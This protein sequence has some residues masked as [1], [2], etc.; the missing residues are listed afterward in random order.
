[1]MVKWANYVLLKAN[2]GNML[3]NYGEMLVNDGEMIVND[4]EISIKGS[5]THCTKID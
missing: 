5:Y 1:M 3:V 2:D 4:G